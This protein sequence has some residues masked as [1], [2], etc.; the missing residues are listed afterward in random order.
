[1]QSFIYKYYNKIESS[2]VFTIFITISATSIFYLIQ[3]IRFPGYFGDDFYLFFKIQTNPDQIISS[4]INEYFYLFYRPINYFYFWFLVNCFGHNAFVLKLISVII[5]DFYVITVLLV[6]RSLLNICYKRTS[7][8]ILLLT[9]L[10]IAFH[11]DTIF[12]IV[13]LSDI[14]EIIMCLFYSLSILMTLYFI[15]GT[16]KSK[17]TVF[18]LVLMFYVLSVLTKQQSLHLPLLVIFISII[19]NKYLGRDKVAFLL[20]VSF[21]LSVV[22]VVVAIPNI[23]LFL[24]P[25]NNINEIQFYGKKIFAVL[26]NILVILIPYGG[27]ILYNYFLQNKILIILPTILLIIGLYH[28]IKTKKVTKSGLLYAIIGILIVSIPRISLPT[29]DRINTLHVFMLWMFIMSAFFERK[30]ILYYIIIVLLINS[31]MSAFY[32]V[33]KLK[34]E[35]AIRNEMH[36]GLSKNKKL[37]NKQIFIVSET[38]TINKYTYYYYKHKTFGMDTTII[39]PAVICRSIEPIL[40]G[41]LDHKMHG[42]TLTITSHSNDRYLEVTK[43][44]KPFVIA[45]MPSKIRNYSQI[46][47]VIPQKYINDQVI[48]MY[49]SDKDWVVLR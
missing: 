10:I 26:G 7:N 46:S 23:N 17:K 48:V 42:D 15:E 34:A 4:N 33:E 22:M 37:D 29:S 13:W 9:S 3:I 19:F 32:V 2:F 8:V 24:H 38:I 30:K 5:G 21:F 1:M 12:S 44:F 20:I 31:I 27:T 47:M 18:I 49:Y 16:L 36:S 35:S 25:E 40:P 14:N 6:G 43:E 28:I 39:G 11:H 45:T 41:M